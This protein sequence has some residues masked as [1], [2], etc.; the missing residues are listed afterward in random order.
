MTPTSGQPA[1]TRSVAG[2]GAMPGTTAAVKPDVVMGATVPS[3]DDLVARAERMI[4]AGR[5][6]LGI[7]GAPGSGKSTLAEALVGQLGKRARLLPMDGFHLAN[8]ELVRR[9]LADRKGAPNTFDIDGY[10]TTLQR[11][12]QRHVDV[13]AP[14]FDRALEAAIAGSIRIDTSANLVVTE[15]NYLLIDDGAWIAVAPLLD[16]C[17][18]IEIDDSVRLQRLVQRHQQFGRSPDAARAWVERVDEANTA[19]IRAAGTPP[20]LIVHLA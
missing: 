3:L 4:G 11:V 7:A 6:V 15:G 9:G 2:A 17:W 5:R 10:V 18:M 19:V 12:R 1:D 20:D 13:L 16:E 8:E 14:R